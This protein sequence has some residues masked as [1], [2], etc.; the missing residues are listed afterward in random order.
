MTGNN[1]ELKNLLEGVNA[2]VDN[3]ARV[4]GEES[5]DGKSG[6]GLFGEVRRASQEVA[7]LK[8]LRDRGLGL[9]LGILI[10][11]AVLALGVKQAVT[12]VLG[13]LK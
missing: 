2:K 11:A 4:L 13:V 3:L 10:V 7:A 5:E 12:T 9:L 1:D 6:T 8:S